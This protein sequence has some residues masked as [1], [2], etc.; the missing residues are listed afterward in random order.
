MTIRS[1]SS[2]ILAAVIGVAAVS[3]TA[4]PVRSGI[5]SVTNS[6]GIWTGRI[7]TNF[8]RIYPFEAVLRNGEGYQV[9]KVWNVEVIRVGDIIRKIDGAAL[10]TNKEMFLSPRMQFT[11]RTQVMEI[12]RGEEILTARCPVYPFAYSSMI[13]APRTD[14]LGFLGIEYADANLPFGV[15][16]TG[17]SDVGMAVKLG[18]RKG[19][20]ILQVN[21]VPLVDSASLECLLRLRSMTPSLEIELVRNGVTIR[22]SGM[23]KNTRE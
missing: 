8:A 7:Q 11:G 10:E 14:L 15:L 6:N 23:M 17:V 20:V 9:R 16:V 19:D 1:L 12:Q 2:L 5:L 21:R 18:I 22:L 4:E 3:W 13:R